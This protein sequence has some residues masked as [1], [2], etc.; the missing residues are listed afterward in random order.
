M[1][2]HQGRDGGWL[3][4]AIAS[5]AIAGCAV[6]PDYQLP[7]QADYNAPGAQPAF[8]GSRNNPVVSAEAPREQWWHLYQSDQLDRQIGRAHV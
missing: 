4:G 1:K 7:K 5:V 2:R 8:V 6:G 3:V